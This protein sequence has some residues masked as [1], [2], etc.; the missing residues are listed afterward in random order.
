[1]PEALVINGEVVG[2]YTTSEAAHKAAERDYPDSSYQIMP[3]HVFF[4]TDFVYK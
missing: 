1:M 3:I 2:I 4:N